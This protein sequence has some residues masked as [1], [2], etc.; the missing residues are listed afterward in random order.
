MRVRRETIKPVI[1]LQASIISVGAALA[2]NQ[3]SD[4]GTNQAAKN[5]NNAKGKILFAFFAFFAD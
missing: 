3:A 1:Q 4:N 2:A 5:A